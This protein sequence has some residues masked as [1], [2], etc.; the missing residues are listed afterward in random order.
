MKLLLT[1]ATGFIG[2]ALTQQLVDAGH[3]V[4]AWVREPTRAR[5]M[6]DSRVALL[7]GPVADLSGTLA[8][9]DAVV[10]LAGAPIVGHRWTR[11][12]KATL[13]SSRV[14]LTEQ[15]VD[16]MGSC[17]G[18]PPSLINASAIGYYG[19]RG[20]T[21]CGE[22]QPAGDDFLAQ[23]C[24]DWESAALTAESLGARVVCP[25]IG[26]VLGPGGGAL[27]KMLPAFRLGAGAR[28]GSGRQYFSWVHIADVVRVFLYVLGEERVRGPINV[29]APQ[30][31]TNREFTATLAK[32]LGRRAVLV[33][34][35]A[36]L[37]LTLGQAAD[38]LFDSIR[39]LPKALQSGGFSFQ[40]DELGSALT[41]ILRA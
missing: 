7:Q 41:S 12:Y 38:A 10:N 23:L 11:S 31:V 17:A 1:G 28:L 21:P 26:I 34:P 25:R 30:P 36:A 4:T 3:Q 27:G 22:E 33:A 24:A 16:A 2:Q 35:R 5:R 19:D 9:V 40:F 20:D 14:A 13:R 6:L 8:Q 29:T 39:A 15:L 37:R 32:T 18:A